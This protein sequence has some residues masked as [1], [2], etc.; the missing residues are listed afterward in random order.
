MIEGAMPTLYT[1]AFLHLTLPGPWK[2]FILCVH[3]ELIYKY[4]LSAS[5]DAAEIRFRWY[6]PGGLD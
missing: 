1:F 4:S 2:V 5:G 6:I 3:K